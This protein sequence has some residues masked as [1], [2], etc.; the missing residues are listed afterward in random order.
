M[1][2]RNFI[3]LIENVATR[4]DSDIDSRVKCLEASLR[5]IQK[6]YTDDQDQ[7]FII[8]QVLRQLDGYL[9]TGSFLMDRE[10]HHQFLNN[11]LQGLDYS[12]THTYKKGEN[13]IDDFPGL[14]H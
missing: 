2:I 5:I 8:R 12:T 13:C 1:H 3:T 14:K 6:N 10:E 4:P 7:W 9:K 11:F